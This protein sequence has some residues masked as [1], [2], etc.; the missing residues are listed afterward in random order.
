M[1]VTKRGLVRW[2]VQN[3]FRELPR[4]RTSHRAFERDGLKIMVQDHRRSD[5]SQ[6][7]LGMLRRQ[8]KTIGLEPT[9][10]E[11]G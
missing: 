10:E 9:E 4:K 11:L 3:G 1:A 5:L 6:K 2:L 8:L 7:H